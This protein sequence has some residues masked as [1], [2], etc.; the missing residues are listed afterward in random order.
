MI[1]LVEQEQDR[2]RLRKLCEKT[3]F[4][5]KIASVISAYGFDKSFACFWLDTNAD[6]AFCQSDGQMILSGTVVSPKETR[7]F[8]RA[9]GPQAIIC[10]VRNAEALS[11]P[12]TDSG[13]VLKKQLAP[14]DANPAGDYD[15]NIREIYSLLE[16]ADMVEEFEPFYLDLSHKLRHGAALALTENRGG[17]L[18]GCALVSSISRKAI[19]LSALAVREQYRRHGIGSGLVRKVESLFPGKT[20]YVFRDKEKNRLFYKE[21][22]YAKTDTWVYS[23]LR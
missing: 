13:D 5:C 20:V 14:G 21:L 23:R 10:A 8:I 9:V 18:A 3:A 1:A 11:L 12:V 22:G 17:T 4:G 15:V 6:V 7:A 19:L 2:A 16:E